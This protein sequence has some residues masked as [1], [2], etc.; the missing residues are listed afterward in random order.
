MWPGMD[1]VAGCRMSVV[2]WPCTCS[3][4]ATR[5]CDA[6]HS[7]LVSA[8]SLTHALTAGECFRQRI[9]AQ[10]HDRRHGRG[11][12]LSFSLRFVRPRH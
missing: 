9:L 10:G 2:G 4:L 5:P 12:G 3:G 11:A 7:R 1:A 8:T 6:V